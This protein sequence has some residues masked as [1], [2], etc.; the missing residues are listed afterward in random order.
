[1]HIIQ[2]LI[3]YATLQLLLLAVRRQAPM[4]S[5]EASDSAARLHLIQLGCPSSEGDGDGVKVDC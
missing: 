3:T 5:P 4:F 1:M 2:L